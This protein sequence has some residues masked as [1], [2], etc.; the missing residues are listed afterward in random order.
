MSL[1]VVA[2]TSGFALIPHARAHNV[3]WRSGLVFGATSMAFAFAGARLGAAIP[4]AIL[5]VAFAALMLVVGTAMFLRTRRTTAP[6]PA[7]PASIQ[8]IL[9]TGIGV[10]LLTGVLG[11]GGGFIIVPALVLVA[12]LTMREAVAT[13]LLVITMNSLSA[14]AGTAGHTSLDLGVL[15][16]VALIAMAGSMLGM[17]LGRRLSAQQLQGGFGVFI[18][19]IGSVILLRELL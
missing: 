12:G 7:H 17:R 15:V 9:A 19:V 18:V 10:G 3:R 4:G 1:V 14:L 16:P 6:A 13:S 11:A 2:V 8:R 5:V